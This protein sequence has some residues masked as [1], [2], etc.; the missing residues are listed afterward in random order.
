MSCRVL[1]D[2]ECRVRVGDVIVP[3]LADGNALVKVVAAEERL[4][5]L[6]DVGFALESDAE[7]LAHGAGAAIAADEIKRPDRR[8]RAIAVPDL[9]MNTVVVLREGDELAAISQRYARHPF[10]DRF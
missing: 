9:R 7:L 8:V 2:E 5:E 10:G 3:P 1:D 4:T 6:H